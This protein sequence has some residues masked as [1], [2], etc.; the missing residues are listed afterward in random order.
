MN[1]NKW[2]IKIF[3]LIIIIL[4]IKHNFLTIINWY[5]VEKIKKIKE[6]KRIFPSYYYHYSLISMKIY[7][8]KERLLKMKLFDY[9]GIYSILNFKFC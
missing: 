3:T 6:L 9:I 7:N 5:E 4:L 8:C 1:N 2:C